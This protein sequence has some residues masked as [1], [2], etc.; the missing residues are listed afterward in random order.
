M[1]G[2]Q[3]TDIGLVRHLQVRRIPFVTFDG[4]DFYPGAAAGGHWTPKGHVLV[5]ERLM[6][7]L[8]QNDAIR[9]D[10]KANGPE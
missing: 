10:A 9:T 4:A 5:A 2:L 6:R 8:R 1:V 7:L 3:T